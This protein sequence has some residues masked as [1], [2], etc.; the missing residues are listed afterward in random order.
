MHNKFNLE[1]QEN[2]FIIIIIII[3]YLWF[4]ASCFIVVK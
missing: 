3:I 1:E 4:R 2:I